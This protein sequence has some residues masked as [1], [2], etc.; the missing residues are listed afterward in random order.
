MEASRM[1]TVIRILPCGMSIRI[2]LTCII[3]TITAADAKQRGEKKRAHCGARFAI[4]S[5]LRFSA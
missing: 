2:F 3:G 5:V 4:V 1:R